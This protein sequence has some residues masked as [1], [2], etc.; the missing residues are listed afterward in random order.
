MPATAKDRRCPAQYTGQLRGG[1]YGGEGFAWDCDL[2]GSHDDASLLDTGVVTPRARAVM[3]VRDPVARVLSAYEFAVEVASRSMLRPESVAGK[4]DEARQKD[5]AHT[6]EVYPWSE[7]VPWM[8]QD[9]RARR[10]RLLGEHPPAQ[11]IVG[12]VEDPYSSPEVVMPLD[13]FVQSPMAHRHVHNAASLQLLGAA[14][15]SIHAEEVVKLHDCLERGRQEQAGP[16]PGAGAGAGVGDGEEG[17]DGG[18]G[19]DGMEAALARLA[20]ARLEKLWFVTTSDNITESAETL[21]AAAGKDLA[22]PGPESMK[23]AP[24]RRQGLGE[25]FMKCAASA[26]AKARTKRLMTLRKLVQPAAGV[27]GGGVMVRFSKEARKRIPEATLERI[28]EANRLDTRLHEAA[29][30]LYARR[31]AALLREGRV[32]ALPRLPES[33]EPKMQE[34]LR[35]WLPRDDELARRDRLGITVWDPQDWQAVRAPKAAGGQRPDRR[36]GERGAPGEA[37]DGEL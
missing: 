23:L 27:A 19:A 14:G 8:Q 1:A 2:S 10:E 17:G 20:E 5:K 34:E 13:E 30:A 28:R 18:G 35:K 16:G 32:Q 4:I 26:Q 3:Q 24:E 36:E 31:R 15:D 9:L 11:K 7:L 25:A 21:A 37:R 22:R 33:F 6:W 29:R 12:V